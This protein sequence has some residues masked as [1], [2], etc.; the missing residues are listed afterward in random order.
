MRVAACVIGVA[1][2]SGARA[3]YAVVVGVQEYL[4]PSANTLRGAVNDAQD[5]ASLLR[6]RGFEVQVLTNR[7]ATKQGV[8]GAL[9]AA[10]A[11]MGAQDRF[12]FYFAGHG[13]REPH[14]A[15]MPHDATK[16]GSDISTE[17]LYRA[18]AAVPA[19]SRTVILDACFSG[20]MIRGAAKGFRKLT[21][22]F[23]E[24]PDRPRKRP[25]LAKSFGAPTDEVSAQESLDHLVAGEEVC[26][27]AAAKPGEA[28]MEEFVDGERAHGVF[29]YSLL[30]QLSQNVGT[31]NDVHLRVKQ[32]V[33]ERL[34]GSGL[35]QNPTISA[36]FV[37]APLF[38]SQGPKRPVSMSADPSALDLYNLDQVN[39]SVLRVSVTPNRSHF[40][41]GE[42]F[43]FSVRTERPG[44]LVVLGRSDGKHYLVHPANGIVEGAFLPAGSDF[45]RG[46]GLSHLNSPGMDRIKILLF[47]RP[48]EAKALIDAMRS[49]ANRPSVAEMQAKKIAGLRDPSLLASASVTLIAEPML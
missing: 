41:V 11:K 33:Q 6:K 25:S 31:W 49:F 4:L 34:E 27:Y 16:T 37:T 13:R 40:R 1:L 35:E 26:Y 2:V 36:A 17:E 15:L 22:R 47:E 21:P 38:S 28:A 45:P 42:Q 43:R 20:G 44:Y 32:K 48:S 5:V 14:H 24:D 19:S 23:W 18:I 12:V 46:G 9:Q 7:Q 10:S 39:E 30:Q 3:D 8:L 29:T